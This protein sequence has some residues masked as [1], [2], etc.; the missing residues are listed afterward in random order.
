LSVAEGLSKIYL[1]PVTSSS[2]TPE[3]VRAAAE[4][5]SELGPVYGDAVLESFL[6]KVGKEIDARVDARLAEVRKPVKDRSFVVAI[7]SVGAGVALTPITLSLGTDR[8][9]S[10]LLVWVALVVINIAAGLHHRP[11]GYSDRRGR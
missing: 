5:H 11:P 3:E 1:V 6:D 7:A 2:L 4:V 8:E 10:L 9:M